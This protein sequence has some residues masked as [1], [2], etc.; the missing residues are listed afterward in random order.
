M[1]FNDIRITVN[2]I[3]INVDFYQL[4]IVVNRAKS[5]YK[6]FEMISLMVFKD[7]VDHPNSRN[8]E[9]I[10]IT[11][12]KMEKNDGTTATQT[13]KVLEEKGYKISR[14]NQSQEGF[15]LELSRLAVSSAIFYE[16]TVHAFP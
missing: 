8:A 12:E 10:K 9:M 1:E 13:V 6:P 4:R 3:S 16:L 14:T 5:R 11:E 2:A 7:L 15:W